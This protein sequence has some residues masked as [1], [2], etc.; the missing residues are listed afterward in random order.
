MK[1]HKFLLAAGKLLKKKR[2]KKNIHN[3]NEKR[4]KHKHKMSDDADRN[5]E[6]AM[7]MEISGKSLQNIL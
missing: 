7:F 2:E 5:N 6:I 1:I 3:E 4:Q